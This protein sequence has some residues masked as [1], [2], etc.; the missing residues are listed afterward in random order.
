M[1]GNGGNDPPRCPHLGLSRVYKA[2]PHTCAIP[3][4]MGEKLTMTSR[5]FIEERPFNLACQVGLE[6][7]TIR[8][9]AECS[10]IELLTI[11]FFSG[12]PGE[13]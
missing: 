5:A 7:T 1:V 13:I 10:T 3:H 12:E 11:K 4:N 8:L 9:T 2:Q 6:P